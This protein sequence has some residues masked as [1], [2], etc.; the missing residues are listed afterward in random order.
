MNPARPDLPFAVILNP[1]AGRG[2]AAREWPRL[3]AELR[4]RHLPFE[5]FTTA[6]GAD[7][8]ARVQ[9]LAPGQPVTFTGTVRPLPADPATAFALSPE[10]GLDQLVQQ[11][12]YVEVTAVEQVQ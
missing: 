6:S 2:L 5:L 3:E 4:R 11:G 8:L 7:A 10:D 12:H 9:A 1:L